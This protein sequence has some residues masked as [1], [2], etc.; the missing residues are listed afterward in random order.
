[1]SDL[2]SELSY[3]R[4]VPVDRLREQVIELLQENYAHDA[5]GMEEYERRLGAA[6]ASEDRFELLRLVE[7]LPAVRP[8]SRTEHP[9]S[10]DTGEVALNLG[11]VRNEENMVAVFSGVDRKGSWLPARSSKLLTLFGGM[12]IDFTEAL[13][14][15]GDTYL[16]AACFLGGV[17]VIV[18]EGLNVEVNG[19]PI[20]GAIDNGTSG[21]FIRGA[22]TLHIRAFVMFGAMDIMHPKKRR[23]RHR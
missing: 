22:P 6:H 14:P 4:K 2:H 12:E 18:P 10:G 1:M 21:E 17:D 19:I 16:E 7:D 9:S 23:R 20:F 8:S 11:G 13:M 15:P 3:I 5:I